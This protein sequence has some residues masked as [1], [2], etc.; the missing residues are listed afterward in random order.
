[1]HRAPK[2][3]AL[4]IACELLVVRNTM[5]EQWT[6]KPQAHRKQN[7]RALYLGAQKSTTHCSTPLFPAQ[8]LL[9]LE[10][11]YCPLFYS[12]LNTCKSHIALPVWPSFDTLWVCVVRTDTGRIGLPSSTLPFTVLLLCVVCDDQWAGGTTL[13]S[14]YLSLCYIHKC[15]VYS[16]PWVLFAYVL[17]LQLFPL[18]LPTIVH[19]KPGFV[20]MFPFSL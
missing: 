3:K 15:V 1:M 4:R 13:F 2:Y 12:K 5:G 10:L 20:H 19:S 14:I 6:A 16:L 9:I 8:A 18:S 7:I 11:M 17:I